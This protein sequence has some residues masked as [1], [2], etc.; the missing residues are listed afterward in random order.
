MNIY[1]AIWDADMRGNGIR[2]I[3]PNEKGDISQG[4][5]VVDMESGNSQ[6]F[7]LRDIHI[8]DKKR[9]SYLLFE[10]LLDNFSLNQTSKEKNTES[11][12]N[13]IED[14]LSMAISSPP[15]VIAKKFIEENNQIELTPSE[16]YTYLYELWFRQFDWESGKDLSGFE[17][18]FIGEQKGRKL[19]GHH[20]WYKYW[21]EVSNVIHHKDQ[22]DISCANQQEQNPVAPIVVTI[23]FHLKAYDFAKRRFIKIFKK[24]CAFFVGLSPEGLLAMGTVRAMP[25]APVN[26]LIN[27]VTYTLELI[28]SPDGKSI[29]TFYPVF[30]T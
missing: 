1:Q 26:S 9:S 10:K 11:E 8:P 24:K 30:A 25:N 12:A 6:H 17:H 5:V 18:V 19:V 22:L 28:K 4:F 23:S 29:R 13:E 3:L 20:F 2:P 27:G 7:I 16:W 15:M 21:L 14:F